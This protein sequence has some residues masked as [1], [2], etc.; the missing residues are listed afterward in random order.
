[1]KQGS[2]P[3]VHSGQ[4]AAPINHKVNVAAVN[5]LGNHVGA[6]PETNIYSG[7]AGQAPMVGTTVHHGGSQG[8][9]K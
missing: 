9:H 5:Q 8:K 2:A 1:M 3:T 7:R 6:H 4:K